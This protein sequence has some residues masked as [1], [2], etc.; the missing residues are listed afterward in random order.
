MLRDRAAAKFD[1]SSQSDALLQFFN[2]INPS[3]IELKDT[4]F[5]VRFDQLADYRISEDFC[6]TEAIYHKK[7]PDNYYFSFKVSSFMMLV[8]KSTIIFNKIRYYY[9]SSHLF[10]QL[11]IDQGII[12][13]FKEKLSSE[14]KEDKM[15][16]LYRI[17]KF[18]IAADNLSSILNDI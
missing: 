5:I 2:S 12:D 8:V 10:M 3:I 18:I 17:S 16:I 6:K 11:Q 13:E 9:Y 15:L 7:V 1:T 4:N 14:S